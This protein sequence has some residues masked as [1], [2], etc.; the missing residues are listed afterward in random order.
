M[1]EL[2]TEFEYGENF[3]YIFIGSCSEVKESVSVDLSERF[4]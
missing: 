3:L 1:V 2:N 4:K